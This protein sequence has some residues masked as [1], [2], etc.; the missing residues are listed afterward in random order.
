MLAGVGRVSVRDRAVD[1][2]RG[3]LMGRISLPPTYCPASSFR[4]W[5]CSCWFAGLNRCAR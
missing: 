3:R 1:Q 5:V 2:T 4:Q